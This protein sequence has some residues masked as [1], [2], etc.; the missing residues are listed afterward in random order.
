[1]DAIVEARR[2]YAH[3][4]VAKAGVTMPA[5]EEAFARVPREAFLG[6]GPWLVGE[7]GSGTYVATPDASPVHLYR[8][9]LIAIDAAREL[10][11]GQPSAH[12][13]WIAAA[14]PAP[15][16]SVFHL[17]TGTGYYTAILAELV[18]PRGHVVGCEIA[19]GLAARARA[20]LAPWPWASVID[21]DGTSTGGMHDVIYVSAGATHPRREWLDALTPAGRLVMPITVH[22]PRFPSHGVGWMVRIDR[23]APVVDRRDGG[24]WPLTMVTQAGFIDCANTRDESLEPALRRMF[25]ITD[26]LVVVREAHAP[27][28]ACIVHTAGCCI[29]RAQ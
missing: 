20:N 9:V 27:G 15:G 28:D 21:G 6:D 17:G 5:L 7:P 12:V 25:A 18:G 1:M 2:T 10:N 14:A 16:E 11:N 23:T 29:Q 19:P 24:P 13:K 4:L 26:P 8:D 22:S 3:A